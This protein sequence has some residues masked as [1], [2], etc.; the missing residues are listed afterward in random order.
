MTYI[1]SWKYPT[2]GDSFH[3]RISATFDLTNN[4]FKDYETNK[5]GGG[6]YIQGITATNLS[7]SNPKL[8][9]GN[10]ATDWTPAPE[11]I[12]SAIAKAPKLNGNN[13]YVGDN[14]YMGT[15]TFMDGVSLNGKNVVNGL[16]DTDWLD[17][18]LAE[19]R[20]GTAKYKVSLGKV[21]VHLDGVKGVTASGNNAQGKIGT[22]PISPNSYYM[23][24][25]CEGS[26]TIR[27][28][29]VSPSGVMYISNALGNT[30]SESD[31]YYSDF[32]VL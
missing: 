26:G 14:T 22:L 4:E 6:I 3:G 30:L 32:V 5:M 28:I 13:M 24:A 1:N 25:F 18:P 20:T 8:E 12:D 9:I 15:N 17:I 16:T 11:D 19:G 21:F 29:N 2:I 23:G 10:V 27:K 7:V 31:S